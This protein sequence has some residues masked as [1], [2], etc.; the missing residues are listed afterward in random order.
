MYNT[1]VEQELGFRFRPVEQTMAD[2]VNWLNR[3]GHI[4]EKEAGTLAD[5]A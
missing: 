1:R 5:V 4:S 2:T 3:A